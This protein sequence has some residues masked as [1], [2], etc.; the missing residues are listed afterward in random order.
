VQ[1]RRLQGGRLKV[2]AYDRALVRI[3]GQPAAD[4]WRAIPPH[5]LIPHSVCSSPDTQTEVTITVAAYGRDNF[6]VGGVSS[7]LRKGIVGDVVLTTST[8]DVGTLTQWQVA[9]MPLVEP[10]RV[11][12]W[13]GGPAETTTRELVQRGGR[14]PFGS[15]YGG[16]WRTAGSVARLDDSGRLQMARKGPREGREDVGQAAPAWRL[17]GEGTWSES[18]LSLGRGGE[19]WRQRRHCDGP[20]FLRCG[21]LRLFCS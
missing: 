9:A 2:L 11:L 15:L 19:Q 4:L 6:F 18:A 20:T 8:G 14:L 5:F 17:E 3:G 1:C 21:I 10:G 16:A 7:A 13:D 12:R